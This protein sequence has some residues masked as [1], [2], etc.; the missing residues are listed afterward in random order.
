MA[1]TI[2]ANYTSD[3]NAKAQAS[4]RKRSHGLLHT[5]DEDSVQRL[6]MVLEPESYV[7]PH[8]HLGDDKWELLV[9]L[10]GSAFV[11][12]FDDE[13][14]VSEKI[15]LSSHEAEGST[16]V[17]IPPNT[18]H[19]LVAIESNTLV[20]EVKPGP[21]ESGKAQFAQW[22]PEPEANDSDS[23]RKWF[24]VAEIGDHFW[25]QAQSA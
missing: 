3:L 21:N 2:D 19:S 18:W 25:Q 6:C 16:A 12:L 1:K 22:A 15:Y 10:K 8:Q 14:S 17:E 20:L 24:Y 9:L 11:L 5:C 7:R 13:G 4:E 23:C